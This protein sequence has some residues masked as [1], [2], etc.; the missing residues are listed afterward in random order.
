MKVIDFVLKNRD[1]SKTGIWRYANKISTKINSCS[2]MQSSIEFFLL[3]SSTEEIYFL[4]ALSSD[5]YISS[6]TI[7]VHRLTDIG[8]LQ[9][10]GRTSSSSV[11]DGHTS[12]VHRNLRVRLA[13]VRHM[14]EHMIGL[15]EEAVV[16]LLSEPDGE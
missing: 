12:Q 8:F 14:A 5:L 9:A 7:P 1:A 6:V 10:G 11:T 16:M 13:S 4:V 3:N 2:W 15:E